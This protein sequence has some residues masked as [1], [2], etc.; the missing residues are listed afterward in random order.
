MQEAQETRGGVERDEIGVSERLGRRWAGN[1]CGGRLRRWEVEVDGDFFFSS[2]SSVKHSGGK[3]IKRWRA[4]GT[5][6]LLGLPVRAIPPRS[7]PSSSVTL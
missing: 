5:M 1:S 7:D 4:A 3:A 2:F 6:L